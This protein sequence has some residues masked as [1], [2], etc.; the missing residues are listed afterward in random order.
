[1]RGSSILFG[2]ESRQ[3]GDRSRS[4]TCCPLTFCPIPAP[5]INSPGEPASLLDLNV[6]GNWNDYQVAT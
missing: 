4:L 5:G 6:M 1:M 3:E 2:G